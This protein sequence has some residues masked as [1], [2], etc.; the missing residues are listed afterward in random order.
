MAR[1]TLE[2]TGSKPRDCPHKH[3]KSLEGGVFGDGDLFLEEHS[4]I[5][6]LSCPLTC[7]RSHDVPGG[8]LRHGIGQSLSE[9]LFAG[10]RR[11]NVVP[12]DPKT[13]RPASANLQQGHAAP[14]KRTC[15][16]RSQWS[17]GTSCHLKVVYNG[18]WLHILQ[19]S[20]NGITRVVGSY[21]SGS[22]V[23]ML[24]RSIA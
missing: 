14:I 19:P 7:G 17:W 21:P 10:V 1:K 9:A 15:T 8:G 20:L 11:A 6:L 4:P 13:L 23:A 18:Y 3:S 24:I 22:C 5:T 12:R 2:R 16:G